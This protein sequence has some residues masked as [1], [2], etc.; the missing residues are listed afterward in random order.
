MRVLVR[1]GPAA[2][3][4]LAEIGARFDRAGDGELSLTREGGHHRDRIA[5]AG[6]DA[7]GAEIERALV[8]RVLDATGGRGHRARAGARPAD[9]TPT[10]RSPGSPCT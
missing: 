5:H 1:E 8:A 3:R 9:A 6:G 2:V 10:A 7:T 4:E